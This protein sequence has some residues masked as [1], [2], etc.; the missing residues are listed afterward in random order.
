MV[1][2]LVAWIVVCA[3]VFF[4]L[5]LSGRRL[6]LQRP[7][8]VVIVV[9]V[10]AR[11]VPL[12]VFREPTGF[13]GVDIEHYRTVADLVLAH[14]DVY[15]LAGRYI[16]IHPY[17]PFFMY[18]LAASEWV[19]RLPGIS[20]FTVV[21]LPLVAAD[22]GTA[23]LVY[24]AAK[25][26]RN[27]VGRATSVGLAYALCPLPIIITVYHGQFDAL[28][29][30]FAFLA[31][32]LINFAKPGLSWA[33]SAGVALGLGI[34][35]KSWPVLLVPALLFR[36]M[37][38][39]GGSTLVHTVGTLLMD[40]LSLRWGKR[41][42]AFTGATIA[43]PAVA[44]MV[45]LLSFQASFGALRTKNLEH[46]S[47]SHTGY[48]DILDHL[49]NVLPRAT[50]WANWAVDHE[51]LIMYPTLLVVAL[52]VIP[53]RGSLVAIVTLLGAAL[54]TATGGGAH[55]FIWLVPFALIAGQRRFFVPFSAA[56][57]FIL[58]DV[59]F[60][61][62]GIYFGFQDVPFGARSLD[63][64][65]IGSVV[66]WSILVL[67][68]LSNVAGSVWKRLYVPSADELDEVNLTAA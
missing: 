30:F 52:V 34:L 2:F 66:V 9:A 60:F 14:E 22:V 17:L 10:V 51:R 4:A 49:A 37:T 64:M 39:R 54:M 43:V 53:K 8:A 41:L 19:S 65:W 15:A 59:G 32:Y 31:W 33:G 21:R 67:W 27:D 11:L 3:V 35:A 25:E 61:R 42:L 6:L 62:G 26:L 16:F 12:L 1:P 20:F 56:L 23:A 5:L 47:P 40:S 57:F 48:A 58:L 38:G 28:P 36:L 18:M 50:G 13:W 46:R 44:V 68:V 7:L 63:H 45:Y 29:L 55:H 24:L